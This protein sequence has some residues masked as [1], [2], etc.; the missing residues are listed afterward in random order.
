MKK[1]ILNLSSDFQLSD[2]EGMYIAT[3]NTDGKYEE[4]KE[5]DNLVL[6]LVKQGLTADDIVKLKNNDLL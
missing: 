3:L 6:S 5:P 4:Y 2:D 1:I